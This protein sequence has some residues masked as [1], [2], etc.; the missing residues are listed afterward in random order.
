MRATKHEYV[1]ITMLNQFLYTISNGKFLEANHALLIL[2]FA[3][4]K[5]E[6]E[7]REIV[8]LEY[9]MI[10]SHLLGVL[11]IDEDYIC[12]DLLEELMTLLYGILAVQSYLLFICT[13]L[14]HEKFSFILALHYDQLLS[15]KS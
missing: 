15:T 2:H 5:L 9:I 4:G 6:L 13:D 14:L 1:L 10:L 12:I 11:L 7:C 8:D 3:V